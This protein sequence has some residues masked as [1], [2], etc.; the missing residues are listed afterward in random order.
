MALQ[1][2]TIE[3]LCAC[4][5]KDISVSTERRRLSNAK[6]VQISLLLAFV[7]IKLLTCF[8][9]DAFAGHASLVYYALQSSKQT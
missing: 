2:S 4:C 5:G 9:V 8:V 6:E 1:S 7:Q 3:I